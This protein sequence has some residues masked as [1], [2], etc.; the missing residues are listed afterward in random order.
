MKY[1]MPEVR[2]LT[3][4]INAIQCIKGEVG[5]LE[6]PATIPPRELLGAYEDWE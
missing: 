4:A 6:S 2:A 3:P 1:E 5:V